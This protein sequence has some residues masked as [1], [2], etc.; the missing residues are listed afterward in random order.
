MDP[1]A[2]MCGLPDGSVL[3]ENAKQGGDVI[4]AGCSLELRKRQRDP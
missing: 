3:G 1:S 4:G 2:A